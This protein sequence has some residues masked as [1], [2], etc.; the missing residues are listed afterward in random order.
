MESLGNST[1]NR[2]RREPPV[3]NSPQ[4]P[5]AFRSFVLAHGRPT[6][7]RTS[8]KGRL[9]DK[10]AGLPA[11]TP[12]SGNSPC[13]HYPQC[14]TRTGSSS[15]LLFHVC[16]WPLLYSDCP[17]STV[18]HLW[19]LLSIR[20]LHLGFSVTGYHVLLRC[21]RDQVTNHGRI[22]RDRQGNAF[23]ALDI[24]A[25]GGFAM[26]SSSYD[27]RPGTPVKYAYMFEKD[28]GPTK[29]F[30]ALLRAIARHVVS[31]LSCTQRDVGYES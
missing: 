2:V 8:L 29:Q 23:I 7:S 18:H 12:T 22:L 9:G 4:L 24:E 25:S 16:C 6:L 1:G 3:G 14:A 15:Y 10:D 20:S 17:L 28:K 11:S 27:T 30:D 13:F 31:D 5:Q 19:P 26:P 21:R